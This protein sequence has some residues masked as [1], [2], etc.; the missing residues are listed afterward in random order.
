M[1]VQESVTPSESQIGPSDAS[2]IPWL[3]WAAYLGAS[4]TWCI[5]MFLPVLLVRDYGFW[6]WLVFAVPNVIGAAAMGWVMN[7][8]ERSRRVIDQHRLA[9]VAFSLVTIIFHVFFTSWFV[10][11]VIGHWAMPALVAIALLGWIVG[12]NR[13][14]ADVWMGFVALFISGAIFVVLVVWE[15]RLPVAH[16]P[17]SMKFGGDALVWLGAVCAFGFAVCPYLDLTF[18]RARLETSDDEAKSAFQIGFGVFFL[19]M[20]LFTLW[21]SR[22]LGSTRPFPRFEIPGLAIPLAGFLVVHVLIQSGYTCALHYREVRKHINGQ[23][24]TIILL[25]VLA[26]VIFFGYFR[27]EKWPFFDGR[28]GEIV[29]RYFM[30]FYGLVFP[31][32]VWLCMV[33]FRRRP[34]IP[35]LFIFVV[36]TALAAPFYRQAFIRGNMVEVSYGLGLLAIARILLYIPRPGAKIA[37]SPP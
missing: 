12:Q 17:L 8:R 7:S 10:R 29:Y 28:L 5:G 4:W 35:P 25:L 9:C 24:A 16:A 23:L 15:A 6:G 34:L 36:A 30:S 31:A 19:A 27:V 14:R 11:G 21:Y 22:F 37:L 2:R 33:P 3:S 13:Q 32:Y 20:I 1:T 26:S 18:H